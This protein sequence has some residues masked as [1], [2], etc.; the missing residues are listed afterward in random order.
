[1]RSKANGPR[2]RIAPSPTG[3]FHVGSARTALF[4]WLVARQGPGGVFI[5]RVED[6]DESRDREEWI[7]GIYSAMAW[8][9]LTIDEGP[10]RQS[11]SKAAHEAAAVLLRRM[12]YLYYCDCTPAMVDARKAPGAPPGYDG[13]CRDR[14][15]ERDEHT[16]L[17]F[18]TPREG[19]TVV[20]DLV[21]GDVEFANDTI[22]DFV[23]VRSSGDVLW[24]L[25]NVN[26][27][28]HDR[29]THVI[30]GEEHLA[31]APK[32]IMLWSAMNAAAREDVPLPLYAH[33]PL[34]VNEQRKKLSKRRD[35]VA[36]E[37]YRDQGYLADAFVNYLALLGWSPKGDREIVPRD[38]LIE[39]FRLEDVSH[40][41]AFFDVK[42][43]THMNGEYLRQLDREGFVTA[44][45]PWVAP[46]STAWQ[47]SDREPPWREDQFDPALYACVAPLV[48]ER[49]ATFGE[50]PAMVEFFFL[51]TPRFDEA[52]FTKVIVVDPLGR[53]MLDGAIERFEQLSEWQAE[54]LHASVAELGESLGLVL[55]KAQAPIRCAVTG[56]LVGPPLFESLE[57]LGRSA[58]IERL[59]AALDRP[60]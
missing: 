45:A 1:L 41:P 26:D 33:L 49:V 18:R 4:N 51:Q 52:A 58:T 47:P 60:R 7:E 43:L 37:S 29:I 19:V 21:R 30:R 53:R 59:R 3:F 9:G 17:R 12:G 22:D 2:V 48:Q 36:T 16:A 23:V 27:D 10:F 34:L 54:T 13:F 39:E 5:L 11:D 56:T 42:K 8:L 24:A 25:A 14:G 38:T 46:W 6:T 57:L 31:N 50:I 35:P 28:R 20:H 44:S 15:L 40:S 32:Q 55:R